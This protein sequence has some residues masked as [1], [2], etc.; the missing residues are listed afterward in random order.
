M[1]KEEADEAEK[2][3]REDQVRVE[4]AI[5]ESLKEAENGPSG[6]VPPQTIEQTKKPQSNIDDLLNLDL[7]PEPASQPQTN[8]FNPWGSGGGAPQAASDPFG[9]PA[10]PWGAPSSQQPPQPPT[11]SAWGDPT[12]SV[13]A[14]PS[15]VAADPWGSSAPS[16]QA[17]DP[18]GQASAFPPSNSS[19]GFGASPTDPF[20]APPP[21]ATN[22]QP[23]P[24]ATDPFGQPTGIN[25]NPASSDLFSL[26]PTNPE[27]AAQQA[28]PF[29]LDGLGSA[30]PE[31]TQ[32]TAQEKRTAQ[33]FLGSA[34]GLVN[35]DNL[36]QRPK[37][38]AATNPFGMTSLSTQA[39][40]NPFHN[41]SPGPSMAEMAQNRQTQQLG[42]QQPMA[43]SPVGGAN[44]MNAFGGM[45]SPQAPQQNIFGVQPMSNQNQFNQP[46]MSMSLSGDFGQSS[47]KTSNNPFL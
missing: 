47:Q 13:T 19:N 17:P 3:R 45:T 30:L 38:P 2:A 32:P 20:G 8:N 39:K 7:V 1:S 4:L 40:S 23:P 43:P 37:Q 6:G 41:T 31:P 22:T 25:N 18:F 14:A 44:P 24:A 33:S 10:D 26:P 15:A 28:S 29:D 21:Q 35:L 9:A 16:S 11:S 46:Q 12:P 5:K 42:L 34:A 36:V 27:P